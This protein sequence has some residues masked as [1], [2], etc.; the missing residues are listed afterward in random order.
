PR[1]EPNVYHWTG[2]PTSSGAVTVGPPTW[3]VFQVLLVIVVW[4]ASRFQIP[5]RV[6]ATGKVPVTAFSGS[7]GP[8]SGDVGPSGI[9]DRPHRPAPWHV[10]VP[11][12]FQNV[13]VPGA[14]LMSHRI[15]LPTSVPTPP[16]AVA[17]E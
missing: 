8:T 2:R 9:P 4:P 12:T 3:I 7:G 6:G 13:P 5:I 17:T 15:W 1:S 16:E 14:P 11:V 10:Q